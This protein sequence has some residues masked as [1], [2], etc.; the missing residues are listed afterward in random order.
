MHTTVIK[1]Y[2]YA[3]IKIF[4]QILSFTFVEYTQRIAQ[5]KGSCEL[6]RGIRSGISE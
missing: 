3:L 1:F 4:M 5:I 2:L 6:S